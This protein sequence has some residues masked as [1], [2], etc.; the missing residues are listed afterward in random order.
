MNFRK[1]LPCAGALLLLPLIPPSDADETPTVPVA[2]SGPAADPLAELLRLAERSVGPT[3]PPVNTSGGEGSFLLSDKVSAPCRFALD[4]AAAIKR[5][6]DA[7]SRAFLIVAERLQE[8]RAYAD[9]L[10]VI[11]RIPDSRRL[12]AAVDLVL[13]ADLAESGSQDAEAILDRLVRDHSLSL[14]FREEGEV[15]LREVQWSAR[16]GKWEKVAEGLSVL[17]GY[18][19]LEYLARAE[20]RIGIE[21]ARAGLQYDFD[22]LVSAETLDPLMGRALPD[23]LAHIGR[24]Q[25][26]IALIEY[27]RADDE[28]GKEKA[29]GQVRAALATAQ[30]SRVFVGDLLVEVLSELARRG[31]DSFAKGLFLEKAPGIGELSNS[32]SIKPLLLAKLAPLYQRWEEEFD[33]G[34]LLDAADAMA[35]KQHAVNRA[36]SLASIGGA[37]KSLDQEDRALA[38]WS[39]SLTLMAGISGDAARLGN[40]AWLAVEV[41]GHQRMFPESLHESFEALRPKI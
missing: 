25:F 18:P 41:S 24:A 9:A 14:T 28:A 3:P 36:R 12:V 31:E 10:A 34:K 37:W 21:R 7:A 4:C 40:L 17:R 30:G 6:R 5:D 32:I 35:A 33:P 20:A 19:T 16:Q 29:R 11:E 26:E 15:L 39:E 38:A 23:F 8:E 2:E 13:A 27:D 1:L 22:A